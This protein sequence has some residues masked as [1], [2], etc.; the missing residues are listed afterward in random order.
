MDIKDLL[1]SLKKQKENLNLLLL[2]ATKKQR[3]IVENKVDDMETCVFAE[4]R[5]LKNIDRL[6]KDRIEL[7]GKYNVTLG[8]PE[9]SRK[10]L[11]FINSIKSSIDPK[12]YE[13]FIKTR[14]EIIETVGKINRANH[15]NKILIQQSISFIKTTISSLMGSKRSSL[16]DRRM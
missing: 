3:A 1:N 16:I 8:I 13:E 12:L 14:T 5:L 2:E 9:N 11:D 10:L 7:I 4:E 15:F 6:E